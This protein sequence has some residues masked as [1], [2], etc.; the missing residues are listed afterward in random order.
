MGNIFEIAYNF[1]IKRKCLKWAWTICLP[2]TVGLQM[3][4]IEL[5]GPCILIH[6]A[7]SIDL[8]PSGIC[9]E[10]FQNKVGKAM[11]PWT[12]TTPTHY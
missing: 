11:V 6:K 12:V 1:A 2:L 9:K 8:M 4:V 3:N 7:M 10:G 5:L